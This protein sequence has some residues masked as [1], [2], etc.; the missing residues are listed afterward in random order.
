MSACPG[1]R[2]LLVLRSGAHVFGVT[3]LCVFV[4]CRRVG[5]V[6]SCPASLRLASCHMSACPGKRVLLVL[7]S[8]AHVSQLLWRSGERRVGRVGGE[9]VS[10]CHVRLPF[11]SLHAI[12]PLVLVSVCCWCCGRVRT[13]SGSRCCVSLCFAGELVPWCHVRLPFGSLHAI[14]PLVLVSVC[15]WCCGRVRTCRNC[16]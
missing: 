12:C 7:L 4:F 3:V 1:K 6:V 11:G 8:G 15:C 9:L 16:C 14:C 5:A 2:V 13:C 10:W